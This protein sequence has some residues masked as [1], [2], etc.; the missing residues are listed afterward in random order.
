MAEP[1]T[2]SKNQEPQVSESIENLD[3]NKRKRRSKHECPFPD[4]RSSVVHLPRHMRVCHKWSPRKS[5]SVLNS[6]NLRKQKSKDVRKTKRS[7]KSVLCPVSDCNSVVKRIHNH[8]TTVH[9]MKTNSKT[10]KE[11]LTLAIPHNVDPLSS[12]ESSESNELSDSSV[13][14]F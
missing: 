8:L 6:F 7:Y 12:S 1:C 3:M 11:H 10:Y 13:S 9:K 5:R 14:S 2:S 4:C